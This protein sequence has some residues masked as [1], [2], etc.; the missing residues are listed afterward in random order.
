MNTLTKPCVYP[1]DKQSIEP[2]PFLFQPASDVTLT[3]AAL[4]LSVPESKRCNGGREHQ[5]GVIFTHVI[6][7]NFKLIFCG[8]RFFM[9]IILFDVQN[10]IRSRGRLYVP[11]GEMDAEGWL[12]NGRVKTQN[13]IIRRAFP[14]SLSLW[15]WNGV[16]W[17]QA[18][19]TFT[20]FTSLD[21]HLGTVWTVINTLAGG[22]Q[23]PWISFS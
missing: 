7:R 13:F 14:A 2:S 10:P 12:V 5:T 23:S 6:N 20:A 3:P 16:A 8:K 15:M 19:Q 1:L 11:D 22:D 21:S 18:L 4:I 17:T 9:L